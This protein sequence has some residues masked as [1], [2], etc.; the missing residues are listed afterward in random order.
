MVSWR[1]SAADP[2]VMACAVPAAGASAGPNVALLAR[3]LAPHSEQKR[4]SGSTA[5]PHFGQV[6]R[7]AQPHLV[8]NLLPSPTS[9][10]Q[11]GHCKVPTSSRLFN[12]GAQTIE[13]KDFVDWRRAW[14]WRRQ[15]M[16]PAA[17]FLSASRSGC[18]NCHVW[19]RARTALEGNS[20]TCSY[21]PDP[22]LDA[23]IATPLWGT[24]RHAQRQPARSPVS[25]GLA[26]KLRATIK[27]G[28]S[29]ESVTCLRL[30]LSKGWT[31]YR[32]LQFH[33]PSA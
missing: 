2:V 32:G 1:R 10:L 5:C 22:I 28:I 31:V 30:N 15:T 7:R 4:S 18:L 20:P 33:G 13:K 12:I 8:Q 25:N 3:T 17:C 19:Q 24:V 16:S 14:A 21:V 29:E 27:S 23:A 26:W 11:S 9:T 6:R